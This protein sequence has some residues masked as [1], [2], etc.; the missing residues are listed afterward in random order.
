[1]AS[2]CVEN[3]ISRQVQNVISGR[4]GKL[5]FCQTWPYYIS[6]ESSFIAD[7]SLLKDHDLKITQKN[8]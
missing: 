4:Q 1:M 2:K 8:I 7:H 3:E 5:L 6:F